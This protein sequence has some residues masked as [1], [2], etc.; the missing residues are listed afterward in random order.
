MNL[1]KDQASYIASLARLKLTEKEAEEFTSQLN[2]ILQFAKQL[3]QLD[4]E[5]IEPM[6]H[7]LAMTNILRDDVVEPSIDQEEALQNAPEKQEG[8]FK[9]PG[10]FQK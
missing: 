9:V 10:V 6:S 2:D 3:E 5:E 8:M 4:T 7:A 1:S